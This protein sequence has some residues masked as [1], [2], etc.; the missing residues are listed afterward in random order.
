MARLTL[1][2][3]SLLLSPRNPLAANLSLLEQTECKKFCFP[4]ELHPL[5]H[6]LQQAQNAL[7]CVEVPSMDEI[8]DLK[9]EE[10]PYD[11]TFDEVF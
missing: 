2:R 6:R 11:Y 1:F 7:C 8:L 5:V 10:Y 3:K 9:S 4:T